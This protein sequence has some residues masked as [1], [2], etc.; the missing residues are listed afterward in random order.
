MDAKSV[1]AYLS[2]DRELV[3]ASKRQHHAARNRASG[4]RSGVAAGRMLREYARK[5]RRNW[6]T[7]RDR[8][9]DLAHHLALKRCIDRAASAFTAR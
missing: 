1:R 8:D 2:R 6:P 5:L 7:A 9:E 4:G 3:A